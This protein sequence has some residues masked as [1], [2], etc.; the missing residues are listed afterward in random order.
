MHK[1]ALCLIH[2]WFS[3]HS[4]SSS[5]TLL[6]PTPVATADGDAVE[7]PMD[8]L[9][10]KGTVPFSH[11]YIIIYALCNNNGA[12]F[13]DAASQIQRS[14]QLGMA[15]GDQAMRKLKNQTSNPEA[16]PLL[17]SSSSD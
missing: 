13:T 3:F 10:N 17:N 14:D 4:A 6:I 9:E 16:N 15:A 5:D 1:I 11:W 12:S 8:I 2:G 7:I